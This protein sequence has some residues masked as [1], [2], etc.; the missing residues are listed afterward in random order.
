MMI[1]HLKWVPQGQFKI[2]QLKGGQIRKNNLPML[3]LAFC[4]EDDDCT[5]GTLEPAQLL[6]GHLGVGFKIGQL[7]GGTDFKEV[8]RGQFSQW[9][10]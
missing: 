7:K 2:E 6:D 10:G 4:C 1:A 5:D 3:C 8:P 9:R